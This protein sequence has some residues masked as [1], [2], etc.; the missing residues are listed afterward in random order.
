MNKPISAKERNLIKGSLRRVF[1][2]SELRREVL[3]KAI[4]PNIHDP[5]RPRVTKWAMCE[6]CRQIEA[7]Y[8]MQVDHIQPLIPLDKSL[9]DMSWDEVMDRLWCEPSNLSVVCLPCHKQKSKQENKERKLLKKAGR[10]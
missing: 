8:K 1:S 3:A 5:E 6:I 9:E 10:K 4:I 7:A 2:R